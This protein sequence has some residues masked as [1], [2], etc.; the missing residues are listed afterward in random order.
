MAEKKL[1]SVV[2]SVVAGQERPVESWACPNCSDPV[3]GEEVL[4]V[5]DPAM[6]SYPWS[7]PR[8]GCVSASPEDDGA[9]VV[10]A[11]M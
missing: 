11:E 5:F 8:C 1:E 3:Y 10:P 9:W 6:G 7:C 2:E 4:L